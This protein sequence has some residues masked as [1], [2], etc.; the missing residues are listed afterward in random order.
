MNLNFNFLNLN[1]LKFDDRNYIVEKINLLSKISDAIWRTKKPFYYNN[2][3][4]VLVNV[5]LSTD[6]EIKSLNREWRKENKITD[7]LSF[8][9][10]DEECDI[11]RHPSENIIG[12]IIISVNTA[13]FQSKKFRNF[14]HE[15]IAILLIHGLT[16]LFGYD[17]EKSHFESQIQQNAEIY[18][19]NKI[20]L[21]SD[22]ALCRR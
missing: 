3:R 10:Y 11:I 1:K 6:S 22:L 16:H 9:Y 14:L 7:V 12:D 17:H 18:L 5:F 13:S 21:N 15:E 19:L 20:N 2:N 8:S 4:K